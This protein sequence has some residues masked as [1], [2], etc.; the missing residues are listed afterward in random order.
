MRPE[1]A[2]L[3]IVAAAALTHV[4]I[5]ADRIHFRG[6][7]V[8]H[9]PRLDW[10]LLR[11]EHVAH[12]AAYTIAL[13]ICMKYAGGASTAIVG[14]PACSLSVGVLQDLVF[15]SMKERH[16]PQWDQFMADIIGTGAGYMFLASYLQ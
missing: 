11:A 9:F 14:A 3:G 16:K 12:G 5:I 15:P 8:Q 10:L 4:G 6:G 13:G 7:F 1:T 2:D